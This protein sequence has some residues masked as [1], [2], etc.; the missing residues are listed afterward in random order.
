MVAEG[1]QQG[2]AGTVDSLGFASL[3]V[4]EVVVGAG[5]GAGAGRVATPPIQLS[6]ED[7]R[8]VLLIASIAGQTS[9]V[10]VEPIA[11]SKEISP[12]IDQILGVAIAVDARIEKTNELLQ[13][14][15]ER[16]EAS[17]LGR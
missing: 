13:R 3:G 14:Q 17:I 5:A 11:A 10:D 1:P 8:L 12:N 2:G 16:N 7:Q 9:I 6:A 15:L 4:E